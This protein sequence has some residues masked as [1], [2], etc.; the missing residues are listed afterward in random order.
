MSS[1]RKAPSS[2]TVNFG[3]SSA[4]EISVSS[5][6]FR[7]EQPQPPRR[8]QAGVHAGTGSCGRR[9]SAVRWPT[10]AS[11]R[12]CAP[13]GSPRAGRAT[14]RRT[15]TTV[16]SRVDHARPPAWPR[17]STARRGQDRVDQRRRCRAR[18]QPI[19][20]RPG[21]EREQRQAAEQHRRHPVHRHPQRRAA[22]P[23]R[24]AT[25]AWPCRTSSPA[26]PSSTGRP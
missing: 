19:T 24:R 14:A 23:L 9:P 20:A 7:A 4:V 17:A 2:T 1:A 16:S 5:A 15:P 10:P 6:D 21:A 22:R 12:G 11:R 8:E 18:A 25:D 26:S 13:G 3:V